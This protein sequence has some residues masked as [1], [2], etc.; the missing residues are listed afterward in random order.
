VTAGA[1]VETR[2]ELGRLVVGGVTDEEL[3]AARRYT[4]GTFLLETAT[5]AGLASTLAALV[6]SG[7]GPDYLW[8]H[9][10][11]IAKTAKSAVD[12]AARRYWAP[13]ALATVVV[14]DAESVTGPLSLLDDL[15]IA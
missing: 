4:V 6:V 5:Q 2:Y 15:T 9:P 1:L 11:R 8:S 13:S 10:A 3:E 14:G 12:E 7:V